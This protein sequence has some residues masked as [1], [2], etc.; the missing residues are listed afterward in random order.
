MADDNTTLSVPAIRVNNDNIDIVPNSFTFKRGGGTTNVRSASA[1]GNRVKSVH[2]KN[3][4]DQI[5]SGKF[6]LYVT[7]A[8]RNKVSDWQDNTGANSIQAVENGTTIPF[9][10]VS[11]TNDPDFEATSD[12]KVTVEFAGDKIE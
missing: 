3:A 6:D 12:G 10:H 4:E 9:N 1:G 7:T 8:N 11:I 2:S 5:S